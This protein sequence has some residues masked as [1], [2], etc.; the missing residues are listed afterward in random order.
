MVRTTADVYMKPTQ[1]L[2]YILYARK[3][4]E[5]EDRQVASIEAQVDVL[6]RL[7]EDEGMR[8]IDVLTEA[9]SAKSPGRPVF[10]EMVRRLQDKEAEGILC[11]KLD[12]LARNPIDGGQSSWRLP[13]GI[14]QHG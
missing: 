12:R 2:D 1:S 10:A 8:I 5:D 13:E 9:R 4:S 6:R 7:A 14:I 11:W 3:S